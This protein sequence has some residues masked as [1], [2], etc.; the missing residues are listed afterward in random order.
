MSIS[1]LSSKERK[2]LKNRFCEVRKKLEPTAGAY[3]KI[4]LFH[5]EILFIYAIDRFVDY[6]LFIVHNSPL[7]LNQPVSVKSIK[8]LS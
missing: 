7:W 1:N 6:I 2:T 3:L 4:L 8:K 5:V